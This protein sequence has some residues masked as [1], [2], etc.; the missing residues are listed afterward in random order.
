MDKRR[1]NVPECARKKK[2]CRKMERSS[3][4][5]GVVMRVICWFVDFSSKVA[6]PNSH[7]SEAG[8]VLDIPPLPLPPSAPMPVPVRDFS[9]EKVAIRQGVLQTIRHGIVSNPSRFRVFVYV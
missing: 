6:R 9:V 3:E 4:A 7:H 8:H 5:N 2:T 1:R